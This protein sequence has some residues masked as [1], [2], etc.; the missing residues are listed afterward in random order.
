[1]RATGQ[2]TR[3]AGLGCFGLCGSIEA[4]VPPRTAQV[5]ARAFQHRL[6]YNHLLSW[7]NRL[8][9]VRL[10]YG[11]HHSP[12]LSR[13]QGKGVDDGSVTFGPHALLRFD[14]AERGAY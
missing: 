11:N 7:P 12:V 4:A 14:A 2:C 10:Y 5:P 13:Q 9:C 6:S 8:P 1:M 3:Q